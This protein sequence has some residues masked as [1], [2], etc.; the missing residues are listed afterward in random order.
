MAYGGDAEVDDDDDDDD[1]EALFKYILL[2][3]YIISRWIFKLYI[4]LF[5]SFAAIVWAMRVL[6]GVL[7]VEIQYPNSELLTDLIFPLL[8][9]NFTMCASAYEL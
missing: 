3:T 1:N 7:I 6:E 8:Y 2:L 4:Y 5:L 9:P